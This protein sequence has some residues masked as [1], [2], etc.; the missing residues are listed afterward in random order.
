MGIFDF[1]VFNPNNLDKDKDN[2]FKSVANDINCKGSCFI[3][4]NSRTSNM[5]IPP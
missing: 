1:S 5:S 3:V 4:R 2:E